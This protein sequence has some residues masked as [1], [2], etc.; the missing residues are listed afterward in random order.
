MRD[1]VNYDSYLD[2]K[3]HKFQC[4]CDTQ[5]KDIKKQER[6]KLKINKFMVVPEKTGPKQKG[7]KENLNRRK[8]L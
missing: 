7:Q 8:F 6:E 1:V 4:T 2:N 3:L 5:N